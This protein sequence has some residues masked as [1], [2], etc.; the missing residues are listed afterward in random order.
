MKRIMR[1]MDRNCWFDT[2][3]SDH[4]L[5]K[6]RR[7]FGPVELESFSAGSVIVGPGARVV[8]MGTRRGCEVTV[9]LDPKRLVADLR[10]SMRGIKIQRAVVSRAGQGGSN[11]RH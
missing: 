9:M 11:H 7:H 1:K 8:L 5:G 4:F 3:E 2:F 10:A 6:M